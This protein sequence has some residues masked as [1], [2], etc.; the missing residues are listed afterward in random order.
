LRLT[1]ALRAE[2]RGT[3]V[4]ACSVHPVATASEFGEVAARESGAPYVQVGPQQAASQVAR[5][6]VSCARRPRPEVYPLASSRLIVW[7]NA[8]SPGLVDR[9]AVW[10]A[11]RGRR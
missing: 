6:I 8:F 7:L 5:A 2:L 4:T 11:R 1:E 10:A 9:L 3:G